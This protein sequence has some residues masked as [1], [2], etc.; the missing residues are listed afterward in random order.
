VGSVDGV[1]ETLGTSQSMVHRVWKANNLKP[2]LVRTFKLSNDPQLVENLRD[3]LRVADI[4]MRLAHHP[5]VIN[6]RRL[7]PRQETRRN[8]RWLHWRVRPFL[9]PRTM[10]AQQNYH[11][12]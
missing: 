7:L 5:D 4:A 9:G 11:H 12:E 2:H 1:A 8:G 6:I 3:R 10:R